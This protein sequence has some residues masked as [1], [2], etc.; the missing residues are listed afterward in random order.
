MKMPGSFLAKPEENGPHPRAIWI[1]AS[2]SEGKLAPEGQGVYPGFSS[3]EA[4]RR[5]V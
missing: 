5:V 2:V 3:P 1:E 4:C